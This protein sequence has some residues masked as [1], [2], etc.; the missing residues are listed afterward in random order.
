MFQ[1]SPLTLRV[2]YPGFV[3]FASSFN[4]AHHLIFPQTVICFLASIAMTYYGMIMNMVM[5]SKVK[6]ISTTQTKSRIKKYTNPLCL[7]IPSNF[8]Y[9]QQFREQQQKKIHKIIKSFIYDWNHS[10]KKQKQM[11]L[12]KELSCCLECP[13]NIQYLSS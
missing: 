11:S 2:N 7:W 1:E 10:T 8:K 5:V 13:Q 12:K 3:C 4:R 6:N 9:R